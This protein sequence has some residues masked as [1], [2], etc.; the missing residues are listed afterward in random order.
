MSIYIR[1]EMVETLQAANMFL[2]ARS[3][4]VAA[5]AELPT[6]IIRSRDNMYKSLMMP[7]VVVNGLMKVLLIFGTIRLF[8]TDV[9]VML[10]TGGL[11]PR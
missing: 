8:A 3:L 2:T 10:I 1:T 5:A 4:V 11:V 9:P 6:D 7:D